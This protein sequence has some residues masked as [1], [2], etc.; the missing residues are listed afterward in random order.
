MT[1]PYDLPADNAGVDRLLD[2]L[3]LASLKRLDRPDRERAKFGLAPPR[4]TIRFDT[5]RLLVGDRH[6][7]N[8]QRYVEANDGLHL[9]EDRFSR[10]LGERST[11]LVS[12]RLL[13]D[14]AELLFIETADWRLFRD[15]GH[16]WQMEPGDESLSVDRITAKIAV[17]LSAEAT[18]L[19]PVEPPADGLPVRIGLKGGKKTLEFRVLEQDGKRILVRP[20][21][22]VAYELPRL[23]SMLAYPLP[24]PG[25]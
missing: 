19:T 2:L 9:V 4:M 22:G 13:P 18:V 20:D 24:P 21:A 14:D 17:W 25:Q 7:Y 3:S 15:E 11:A 5:L 16:R 8:L 10:V 1:E 6:P 12:H 23:D